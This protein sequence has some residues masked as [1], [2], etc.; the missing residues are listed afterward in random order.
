MRS[1]N[2]LLLGALSAGDLAALG[3][4]LTKVSLTRGEVLF[5]PGGLVRAVHFPTDSTVLTITIPMLNGATVE[6]V[7]IGREGAAG[8]VV[9]QGLV[10]AFGRVLTLFPGL[11][12][13]ID[14]PDLQAIK[15][16]SKTVANLFTRYSDCLV[17][18][19][20]QGVAC[21]AQHTTEQRVARWLLETQDRVGDEVPL[22]QE[23][24]AQMLG[25][26]RSYLNKAAK[27]LQAAG[28][29]RYHRGLITIT[30][31]TGLEQAACECYARIRAH[32]E[33]VLAGLYPSGER[34]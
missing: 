13:R 28:L 16:G 19:L 11:A 15:R 20:Q 4:H 2:N 10:P 32:Y 18:Q 9:S 23:Y 7:T 3:R 34:H 27:A 26:H 17:A 33:N 29:I 6:T 8:G 14:I 12:L 1:P 30:N 5:E 21:N 25:I 31:R 22:T 24:L